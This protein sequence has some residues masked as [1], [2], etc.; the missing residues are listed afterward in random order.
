EQGVQQGG[1]RPLTEKRLTSAFAKLQAQAERSAARMEAR[2]RRGDLS[3]PANMGNDATSVPRGASA[4][5]AP[6]LTGQHRH[7]V[8]VPP[9]SEAEILREQRQRQQHLFK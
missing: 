4:R 1:G 5:L 7:A 9:I 2:A 6:E 3:V 8:E